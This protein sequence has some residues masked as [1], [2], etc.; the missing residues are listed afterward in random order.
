M[1]G[2]LQSCL[3]L[4]EA[5]TAR[6]VTYGEGDLKLTAASVSTYPFSCIYFEAVLGTNTFSIVVLL[7]MN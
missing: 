6:F 7:L 3:A 1:A 4:C 5:L 2:G